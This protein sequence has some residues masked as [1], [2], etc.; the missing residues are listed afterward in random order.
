MKS[1]K[2]GQYAKRS[3]IQIFNERVL[4]ILPFV[5]RYKR[6]EIIQI[7]SKKFSDW[8]VTERQIDNYV[9]RAREILKEETNEYRRTCVEN[10]QEN[11]NYVMRKFEK[12]EDW[13][14]FLKTQI[15]L[16]KLFGV[17][18]KRDEDFEERAEVVIE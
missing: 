17:Y 10:A 11:F 1:K 8:N 2:T 7:V 5:S 12:L 3:T 14:G 9:K 15:E 18:D 6:R 13:N 4:M 16:N